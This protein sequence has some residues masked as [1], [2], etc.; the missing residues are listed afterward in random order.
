[1]EHKVR[2]ELIKSEGLSVPDTT[3]LSRL[4]YKSLTNHPFRN[5]FVYEFPYLELDRIRHFCSISVHIL[6]I[7]CSIPVLGGRIENSNHI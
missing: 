4:S 7:D 2:H 3:Y 1:M 6:S 5:P